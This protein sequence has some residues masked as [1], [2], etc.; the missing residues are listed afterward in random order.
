MACL[1]QSFVFPGASPAFFFVELI[2]RNGF[3]DYSEGNSCQMFDVLG[4]V[5]MAVTENR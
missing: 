1:R 3:E 4:L 2:E 5:A